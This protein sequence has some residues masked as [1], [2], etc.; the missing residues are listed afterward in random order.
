M[1]SYPCAKLP[2]FE[3]LRAQSELTEA[4]L[5]ETQGGEAFIARA[6]QAI[7]THVLQTQPYMRSTSSSLLD[8]LGRH[9]HSEQISRA[10]ARAWLDRADRFF[11]PRR[12]L[13][14][15]LASTQSL[16]TISILLALAIVIALTVAL[17][18]V[19]PKEA[20][21]LLAFEPL[22]AIIGVAVAVAIFWALRQLRRW[23]D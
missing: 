11:L 16:I 21:V 12:R 23:L 14:D 6:A 9:Y 8:K 18:Y 22:L 4:L 10:L 13:R 5:R 17:R 1:D 19:N 2:R 7:T 3:E 15:R 20:A